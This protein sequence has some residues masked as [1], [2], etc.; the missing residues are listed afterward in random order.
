MTPAPVALVLRALGLGDLLTALPAL[1]AVRRALSEHHLVLA[2][3]KSLAPLALRSG[4]VD[5]TVD[6]DAVR[7][8]AGL[9]VLSELVDRPDVA[10]NLHGRGPQSHRALLATRPGRLV[11]YCCPGVHDGPAYDDGEHEV[12][13]WCRL[14]TTVLGTPADPGDLAL[15][16]GRDPAEGATRTARGPHVVVHPGASDLG[17]A[18]PAARFAV[19]ARALKDDGHAVVVTGVRHEVELAD[20]VA[21]Q[22]GL[23]P[24]SVLAGR[25]DVVAFA[26][27]V[28]RARLVVS[29]DTGAGH[30]A[31]ACGTPSVLVFGPTDPAVWGPRGGP[32]VVLRNGSRTDDVTSREVVGACRDALA[33]GVLPRAPS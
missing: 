24:G 23:P 31:T 28:G 25:T 6:V 8:P 16:P 3:P 14:V 19:V 9:A 32:H 30:L 5:A 12:D 33:R 26:D 15:A 2:V 21:E 27:L 10:V 13:R 20:A 18:W 17:K 1:R 29:S 22:A 4:A 7:D 11:A